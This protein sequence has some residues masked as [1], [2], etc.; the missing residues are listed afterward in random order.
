MLNFFKTMDRFILFLI[1]TVILASVLPCRGQV[2][3]VFGYITD[4]AIALLF[5]L[6]GAK[7][8][9]QAVIAGIGHWRLHLV[10]LAAT[11][12]IYPILGLGTRAIMALPPS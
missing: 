10:V 3:V 2:A 8:S 6:H 9:R 11:F 12:V 4:L 1:A 5:F 7:L